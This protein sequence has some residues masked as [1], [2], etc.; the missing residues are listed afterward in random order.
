MAQSMHNARRTELGT[1]LYLHAYVSDQLSMKS[2]LRCFVHNLHFGIICSR[3]VI[4]LDE[5]ASLK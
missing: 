3:L 5:F 2:Q 1:H 4:P